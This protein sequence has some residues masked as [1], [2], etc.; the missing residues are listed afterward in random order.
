MTSFVGPLLAFMVVLALIPLAL[1]ALKRTPLGQAAG[2]A[3]L[4]LVG[5][6]ALAPNQRL[7]TVEVGSGDERRWLVLGVS[8]AGIR[9]LHEMAPQAET[10]A[11]AAPVFAQ[12]LARARGT[13][14][15]GGHKDHHDQ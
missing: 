4:R 8:A 12:L 13:P 9:T 15:F 10:P 2:G 11:P 7:V 14:A 5:Q 1:W 3:G 6:L